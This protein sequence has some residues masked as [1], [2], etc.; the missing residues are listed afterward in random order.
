MAGRLRAGQRNAVLGAIAITIEV[1][2]VGDR[3]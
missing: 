3:T 1:D 2:I